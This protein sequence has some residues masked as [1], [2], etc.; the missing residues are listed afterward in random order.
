M[1]YFGKQHDIFKNEREDK[2]REEGEIRVKHTKRPASKADDK[3]FGEYID[4]E[5]IDDNE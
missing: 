1:H 5:E 3:S 2:K 4:F